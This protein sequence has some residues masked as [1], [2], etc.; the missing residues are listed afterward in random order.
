M[1][2]YI[3][4]TKTKGNKKLFVRMKCAVCK[5]INYFL[6]KSRQ[7]KHIK[8]KKLVLKKFCKRCIKTTEHKESKK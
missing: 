6:H 5:E 2:L 8:E 4:A 1:P 7:I 3:M